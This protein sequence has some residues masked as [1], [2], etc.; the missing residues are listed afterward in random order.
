MPFG[1]IGTSQGNELR[2]SRAIEFSRHRWMLSLLT[3]Q[4]GA[5]PF[6]NPGFAAAFNGDTTDVEGIANLLVR[7]SRSIRSLIR[8]E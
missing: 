6:E 4:G 8:F 7:P 3:L 5:Q 2:F 1:G